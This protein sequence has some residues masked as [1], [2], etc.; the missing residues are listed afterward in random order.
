MSE[1]LARIKVRETHG[2]RRFLYPLTTIIN[3]PAD[4]DTS[5]LGL[6]SSLDGQAI[7]SQVTLVSGRNDYPHRLDFAISLDPFSEQDLLLE[8]GTEQMPVDDPL[9]FGIPQEGNLQRSIQKRFA[10]GLDWN[11]NICDV[12]YDGIAHLRGPIT[13]SRNNLVRTEL[14][15]QDLSGDD[16]IAAWVEDEGQYGDSKAL[17][18]VELTACK[19]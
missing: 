19:S 5:R 9:Y 3:L 2:I 11:A 14:D 15:F 8:S 10:I 7:P 4:I 12:T 16:L 17:T 18:R 13:I 6:F 1:V